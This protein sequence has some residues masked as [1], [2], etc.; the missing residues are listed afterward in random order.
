MY[1]ID[2][3]WKPAPKKLFYCQVRDHCPYGSLSDVMNQFKHAKGTPFSEKIAKFYAGE[4]VEYLERA[5]V[6]KKVYHAR[7]NPQ[8]CLIYKN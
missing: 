4:I 7:L 5:H 8:N 2:Y 1:E 6:I 3:D